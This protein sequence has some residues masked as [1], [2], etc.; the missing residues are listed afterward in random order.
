[1]DRDMRLLIG[2][3]MIQLTAA[4]AEIAEIRDAQ[5]SQREVAV[6][7]EL[8]PAK[9]NGKGDPANAVNGT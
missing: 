1:M 2:D 7:T 5:Q 9:R 3:L 8:P 4:R 6:E